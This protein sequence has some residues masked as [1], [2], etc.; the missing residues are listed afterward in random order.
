[1]ASK[2]NGCGRKVSPGSLIF[3]VM[4]IKFDLFLTSMEP[5]KTDP[6]FMKELDWALSQQGAWM[7]L[8]PDE[9]VAVF[10][11]K[12]VSHG[13]NLATV[14]EEAEKMT[15]CPAGEIPVIFV[16]CGRHLWYLRE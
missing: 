13:K 6:H 14:E 7:H 9:W 12:V 8:Y 2:L 3:S 11:R 16:E 10:E 15:K 1:M 5:P 4:L